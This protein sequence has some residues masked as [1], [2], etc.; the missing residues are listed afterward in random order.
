[1]GFVLL[2]EPVS[3]AVCDARTFLKPE[4]QSHLVDY[5][6]LF[7]VGQQAVGPPVARA[8]WTGG[9]GTSPNEQNTQQSPAFGRIRT[10]QPWQS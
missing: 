7:Y 9:Q 8:A 3:C 6:S 5:D 10:P 1:M 4:A 2:D